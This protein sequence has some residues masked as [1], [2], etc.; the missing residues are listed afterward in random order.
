MSGTTNGGLI[1]LELIMRLDSSV[2][3]LGCSR[4]VMVLDALILL[5]NSLLLGIVEHKQLLLVFS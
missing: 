4:Q 5:Y 1:C 3:D 2:S